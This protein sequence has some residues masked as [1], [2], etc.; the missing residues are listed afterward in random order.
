MRS[1][2]A[3][4]Q[5]FLAV[6]MFSTGPATGAT[7]DMDHHSQPTMPST[8]LQIQGLDGK[9]VTLSPAE[10]AA[11]PHKTVSVFNS[12]S[13]TNEKYSGVTLS[14]L[15]ARV[16]VPQGEKVRGKVFLTGIIAEGTDNYAVL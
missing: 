13:K 4:L 3:L 9:S 16:G 5:M 1:R 2:P 8:Q 7:Q 10:F 14:D 15:L 6:L 11:L 12:H